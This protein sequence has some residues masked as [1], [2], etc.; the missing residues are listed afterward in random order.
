M[1]AILARIG[2]GR[3]GSATAT[4]YQDSQ[5]FGWAASDIERVSSAGL[6]SGYADGT[7]K[8]NEAITRAEMA[9]I[10]VRWLQ[11]AGEALPRT[12]IQP[13][14]GRRTI[15]RSWRKQAM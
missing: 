15:L 2:A 11:L 3:E 10:V 13:A 9:A 14:I 1:A 4:R 12:R 5:A 6:M 8:P 7:F